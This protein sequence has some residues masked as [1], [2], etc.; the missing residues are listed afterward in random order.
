MSDDKFELVA[1][2]RDGSIASSCERTREID[3]AC[4]ATAALYDQLGFDPPWIGYIAVL[5][6]T[7]VGGG[8]FVG[9]PAGNRVE[10]AYFTRSDHQRRGVATRTARQLVEIARRHAPGIELYAKTMPEEN[11]STRILAGLGF[12]RIGTDIDHEIGEAWAWLLR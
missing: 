8:A 5:S 6:G 12:R 9:P 10:I 11:A 1:C 4:T 3:Q 2:A 7:A